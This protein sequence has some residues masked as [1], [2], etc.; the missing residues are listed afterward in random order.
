MPH[1]NALELRTDAT[2]THV[3]SV[4]VATLA[5]N[6]FTATARHVVVAVGGL[7]VP[8]L[9][10]L[11]NSVRAAGLGNDHDLVGR[12]FMDHVEG[13]VG[14]A[15]VARPPA[16]VHAGRVRKRPRMFTLTAA[17]MKREELLGC[18]LTFDD[19]MGVA[20]Y[21]D[22]DT[23]VTAKAVGELR[24][25]LGGGPSNPLDVAV[26]AEPKPQASSRVVLSGQRDVLGQPRLELQY[27]R[28]PGI[29]LPST[30]RSS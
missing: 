25:S 28:S 26:R 1:A 17:A 14:T 7:E 6:R 4:P 29:E 21:A 9:L 12:Y 10:L 27:A 3:T 8:R 5:G 19:N 18:A 15:G 30:G 13:S 23:G 24:T 16:R 20:K 11:S 22:R 2:A